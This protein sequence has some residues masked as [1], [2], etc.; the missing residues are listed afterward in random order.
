MQMDDDRSNE[1]QGGMN[2][3]RALSWIGW[4]FAQALKETNWGEIL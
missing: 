2:H 3:S 1:K 4:Q